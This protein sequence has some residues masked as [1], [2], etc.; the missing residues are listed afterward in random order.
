MAFVPFGSNLLYHWRENNDKT[1]VNRSRTVTKIFLLKKKAVCFDLC[2]SSIH[3]INY[4][5]IKLMLILSKWSIEKIS[6]IPDSQ[7]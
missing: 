4:V 5:C 2:L 6:H 3:L 1:N 7:Q